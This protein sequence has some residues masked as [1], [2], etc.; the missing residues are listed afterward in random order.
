M[1]KRRQLF[2]VSLTLLAFC[3]AG[4]QSWAAEEAT[5]AEDL[6]I[7]DCLLPAKVRRLGRRNTFLAPRQPIR[8]TAVDCR[9][10]GGEYTEPD[11]ATYA[12]AL[13]VWLPRA[14]EGD[15]EAHGVGV[16]GRGE[17]AAAATEQR[18]GV[19]VRHPVLARSHG[20]TTMRWSINLCRC[21]RS[22]S[23]F[24]RA[25]DSNVVPKRAERRCPTPSRDVL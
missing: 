23:S 25:D 24:A 22:M 5:T 4:L 18:E 1:A 12:T 15:V 7:V 6:L 9:I 19:A 20:H 11:Q 10:R 17:T 3:L 8:T 2:R 14:T 16:D 13:Q 21:V